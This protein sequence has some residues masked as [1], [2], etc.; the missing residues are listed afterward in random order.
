MG[1]RTARLG[2]GQGGRRGVAL[3][4]LLAAA[5]S[6]APLAAAVVVLPGDG[7]VR[8]VASG[9]GAT[10]AGDPVAVALGGDAHL[11]ASGAV[12]G[13][14]SLAVAADGPAQVA[15]ATAGDHVEMTLAG[16][17]SDLWLPTPGCTS[18]PPR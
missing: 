6:T 2:P 3:A 8:F 13:L 4:M 9:E 14:L 7:F 15:A 10:P 16:R 5:D 1:G 12:A 11:Q 17:V 18:G